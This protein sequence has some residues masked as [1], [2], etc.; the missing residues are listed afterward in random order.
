MKNSKRKPVVP[1]FFSFL[2]FS[3]MLLV[4]ILASKNSVFSSEI[5]R[6]LLVQN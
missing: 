3:A 5:L 6:F 1:S 4:T 2:L